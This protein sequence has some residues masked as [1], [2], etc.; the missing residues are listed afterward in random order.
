[1]LSVFRLVRDES[2]MWLCLPAT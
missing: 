2:A 1:M